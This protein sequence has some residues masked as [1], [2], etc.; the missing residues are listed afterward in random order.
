MAGLCDVNVLLALS[1]D[2]HAQH[3]QALRWFEGVGSAGARVCR[4]A[5]LGL[6]RLL[7]N[8][9]AMEEDVL[10]AAGCWDL[11]R[12][13]QQDERIRFAPAEPSGLDASFERF[14]AGQAFSPRLWTDAYLAAFA[15]A[16]GLTVVTF[17]RG[18]RRFPDLSCELLAPVGPGD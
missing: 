10:D 5:L 16:G 2:R 9:S 15:Q 8:P 4:V 18:F 1:T 6:L 14:T 7:N 17:D 13:M 12:R 3:A 11:W